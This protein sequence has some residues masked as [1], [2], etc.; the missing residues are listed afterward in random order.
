MKFGLLAPVLLTLIG[1]PTLHAQVPANDVRAALSAIRTEVDSRENATYASEPPAVLRERW[2]RAR[3]AAEWLIGRLDQGNAADVTPDYLRSLQRVADLTREAS[4][5]EWEDVASELEAKVEHCRLLK[6]GMGGSVLL[7]IN[8]RTAA[9]PVGNWQVVYLLKIYE[10]VKGAAPTNFP[11][12]STPTEA[13]IEP[14]RY[15]VWA[16]DPSTGRTSERVLVRA[17]GTKELLVDLPVP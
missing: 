4:P 17:A 5:N 11:R 9:G 1:S 14:G 6:V 15:W 8:T 13:P 7:K 3:K 2:G 12:L 16:R 10:S